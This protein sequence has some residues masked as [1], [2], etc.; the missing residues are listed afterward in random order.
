MPSYK[1]E[2]TNT[3]YCQ[4]WYKDWTNKNRHTCKRGFKRKR[5]ADDWE[6]NFRNE[7]ERSTDI[8]MN[9]LFIQYEKH[10]YNLEELK[11]Y[12]KSTVLFK[13]DSIRYYILPYFTGAIVNRV[14]TK[15]VNNWIVTLKTKPNKRKPGATLSS[16][17]VNSRRT[18]LNQIFEYAV[19]NYGLKNNPV[20]KSE[21][22]KYYSTD[23]RAK[24]WTLEQYNTF[25]NALNNEQY[26]II[27]NL[28]F[29]S[30][31]RIGEALALTPASFHPYEIAVEHN[32]R[33]MKY[34]GVMINHMGP[35]KNKPS[36]RDIKIPHFLY[37]QIL[38]YIDRLYDIKDDDR[39]IEYAYATIYNKM[40]STI[41]KVGLPRI[42]PHI[43]RH[44]YANILRDCTDDI[45]VVSKQ[46]GHSSPQV[47]LQIYT[48]MLPNRDLKAVDELEKR[49]LKTP[50]F[51][52]IDITNSN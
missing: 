4:F 42:S 26:R 25:Y 5:D 50:N 7:H 38:D 9:E 18:V 41:K 8:T 40:M 28:M 45:A 33:R 27:F 20:E 10:L 35:P 6:R 12:G 47:T 29:Y 22:A 16:A 21:K 37:N 39:I 52:V 34:K 13:L 14:T 46:L 32:F 1:D 11:V 30:G 19:T 23:D 36:E 49:A 2:K 51:E 15:D 48:H 3:W 17:T 31:M 44:S 43:L 24:Y